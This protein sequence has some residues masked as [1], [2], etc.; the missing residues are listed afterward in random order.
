[1]YKINQ[2]WQPK[3]LKEI[4]MLKTV[5]ATKN[6]IR[7]VLN[8]LNYNVFQ[9]VLDD[10]TG[11][12]KEKFIEEDLTYI[13]NSIADANHKHKDFDIALEVGAVITNMMTVPGVVAIMY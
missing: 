13:F 4:T 3:L 12:T 9:D 7:K 5:R 1:M 6:E 10:K 11:R 8:E 2:G